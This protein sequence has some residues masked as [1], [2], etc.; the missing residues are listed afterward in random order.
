MSVSILYSVCSLH[1]VLQP[2]LLFGNK[3]DKWLTNTLLKVVSHKRTTTS[4]PKKVRPS[5]SYNTIFIATFNA[6][7][8]EIIKVREWIPHIGP[9]TKVIRLKLFL[10]IVPSSSEDIDS[11]DAWTAEATFSNYLR[12][13]GGN[14]ILYVLVSFHTGDVFCT[15]SSLFAQSGIS[16]VFLLVWLF[17]ILPFIRF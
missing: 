13:N 7:E 12:T 6:F 5:F 15:L 1:F 4:K 17:I 11:R 16:F 14:I 8:Q 2:Y 9:L 3:Y 10:D